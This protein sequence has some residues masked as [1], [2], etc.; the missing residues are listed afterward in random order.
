MLEEISPL[1][2][3]FVTVIFLSIAISKYLRRPDVDSIPTVGPGGLLTSYW[4]ALKFIF[5]AREMLQEGYANHKGMAFKIPGLFCWN[6]F[7]SGH[8]LVEEMRKAPEDHIS[9]VERTSDI[10]KPKYTLG[11]EIIHN[12]YHTPIILHQLT[13][14]I[15][16][17]FPDMLDEIQTSFDDNIQLNGNEWTS[18]PAFGTV[19]KAMCRTSNRVLVGL[20]LCRDPDWN[21]LATGFALSVIKT[22]IIIDLFPNFM[23]PVVGTLLSSLPRSMRRGMKHLRPIIEERQKNLDEYGSDWDE[24]PSDLLS[25]L[26]DEA[27]GEERSAENLVKRMLAINF[28]AIHSSSM[29]FTQALYHLAEN[30][31]YVKPLREEVETIV[32]EEGWSKAALTKMRK[33]DSFM[34]E[35]L[36]F[37]NFAF[38]SL[39]RKALKDFTFSNG[40]V[41]PAGCTVSVASMPTHYDSEIYENADVFNPFRFANEKQEGEQAWHQMVSTN[42]DYLPFGHGRGS[43]PG[44]FFAASELKTMLAHIVVTYDIKFEDGA[45]RPTNITFG[46]ASTPNMKAKLLFRKRVVE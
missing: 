28:T 20:P 38:L 17:K 35:T 14:S 43:C 12:P 18:V 11:P 34:K 39:P 32:E 23:A 21:D 46:P 45:V 40:I 29:M 4:G 25:W 1:S 8:K 6:V 33:V 10:L 26:M 31:Q 42:A 2:F 16:A 13:R 15:A 41:V 19:V 22:A 36:R 9:V 44:R 37:D 24:K 5:C 30:P 7:L 3:T 27:Q